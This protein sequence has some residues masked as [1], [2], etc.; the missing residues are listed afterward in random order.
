MGEDRFAHRRVHAMMA[1]RMLI[2]DTP[3]LPREK[4]AIP[5][6]KPVRSVLLVH[7]QRLAIGIAWAACDVVQFEIRVGR[8]RHLGD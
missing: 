7:I 1:K 2:G 4:L 3:Q 6:K 8:D 5:G